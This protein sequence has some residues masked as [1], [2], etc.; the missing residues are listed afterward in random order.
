[1]KIATA[2]GLI[3]TP[4]AY[5]SPAPTTVFATNARSLTTTL[6]RLTLGVRRSL[7]EW[8]AAKAQVS[9]QLRNH[10]RFPAL[11]NAYR[12]CRSA[13]QVCGSPIPL[14]FI[15]AEDNAIVTLEISA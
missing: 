4:T 9:S 7:N 15:F 3:S 6:A 1:M 13:G 8:R 10:A 5:G 14:G 11:A 2:S 12:S